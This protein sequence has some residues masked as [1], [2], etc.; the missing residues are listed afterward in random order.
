MSKLVR[1]SAP[2]LP[3]RITTSGYSLPSCR[4]RPTASS[5]MRFLI[6]SCASASVARAR[7]TGSSAV[8]RSCDRCVCASRASASLLV[9]SST[10]ASLNWAS[11]P[12]SK[13]G[14]KTATNS[15]S[16]FK[17]FPSLTWSH[18]LTTR[19][20]SDFFA[21]GVAARRIIASMR[22]RAHTSGRIFTFGSSG[23]SSSCLPSPR[24]A[25]AR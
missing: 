2:V 8:T 13:N 16:F 15:R 22:P 5:I 7:T 9:D 25:S 14:P 11:R 21:S 12:E 6:M 3:S 1:K 24:L 17:S 19:A 18:S 20:S 10:S 4:Y 23:M